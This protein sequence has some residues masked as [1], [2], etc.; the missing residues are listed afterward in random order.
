MLDRG[1][2]LDWFQSTEIV[3]LAVVSALAFYLFLVHSLTTD[4]PLIA[5]GVFRDRNFVAGLI[6]AFLIAVVVLGL[7]GYAVTMFVSA[8]RDGRRRARAAK[9]G[10]SP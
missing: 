8:A 3:T 10:A 9:A 1:H 7:I 6:I 2:H 5:F 4:K